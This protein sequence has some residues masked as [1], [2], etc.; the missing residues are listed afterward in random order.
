[1]CDANSNSKTTNP[2]NNSKK[3]PD[4]EDFVGRTP[5]PD[6][7]GAGAG[8]AVNK[9]NKNK[10]QVKYEEEEEEVVCVE[11]VDADEVEKYPKKK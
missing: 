7:G 4:M 11:W 2:N 1:M 3:V 5:I 8:K 6:A 10:K 9:N